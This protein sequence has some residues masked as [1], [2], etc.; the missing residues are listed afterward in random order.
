MSVTAQYNEL[1]TY[2]AIG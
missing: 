2:W 1:K